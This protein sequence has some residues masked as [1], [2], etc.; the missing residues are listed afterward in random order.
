LDNGRHPNGRET[1]FR[2]NRQLI[3]HRKGKF[4]DVLAQSILGLVD[5]YN[6][7]PAYVVDA[8]DTSTF[9]GMLQQILVAAAEHNVTAWPNIFSPRNAIFAHPLRDTLR[10]NFATGEIMQTEETYSRA[11]TCVRGWL[12]FGQ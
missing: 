12:S 4:L 7:L 5:V 9:Q 10:I 8:D 6:L 3:T 1:R 11:S 2:H